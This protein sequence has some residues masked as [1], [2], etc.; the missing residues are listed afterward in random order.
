[1]VID[2]L[3]TPKRKRIDEKDRQS[4]DIRSN[5]RKKERLVDRASKKKNGD[6]RWG[7]GQTC[8]DQTA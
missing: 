8:E 7:V 4:L 1:M 5:I 6:K 3:D 2:R